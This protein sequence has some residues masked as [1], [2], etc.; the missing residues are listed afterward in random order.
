VREI[1][2]LG[3]SMP[4]DYLAVYDSTMAR[5]WFFSGDARRKIVARLGGLECGRILSDDDL[6]ALG[7]LFPDRR[8]GELVFLLDPGWLVGGSD[9]NGRWTPDG[10]H[11]YHPDDSY[12]DG[13][14]LSN[15][16]PAQ[17]V[18]TVANVYSVMRTSLLTT[19]EGHGAR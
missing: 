5:F 3:L 17:P 2:Q 9:F 10:M 4:E 7:I 19:P 13:I 14:F 16:P 8:Y 12:S 18:P 15:V 6:G 1:E 11:G